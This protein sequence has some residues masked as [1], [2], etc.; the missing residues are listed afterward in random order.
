MPGL[1]PLS[2]NGCGLAGK[3]LPVGAGATGP[4]LVHWRGK[5]REV[6]RHVFLS[7][8]PALPA[9]EEMSR[10]NAVERSEECW[11]VLN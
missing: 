10:P 11:S 2:P 3:T 6:G 9:W 1:E 8:E 7:S 5:S 4:P